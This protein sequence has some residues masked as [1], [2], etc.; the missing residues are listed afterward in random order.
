MYCGICP[1]ATDISPIH[2]RHSPVTCM[3]E[4][5]ISDMESFGHDHLEETMGY[6]HTVEGMSL[7]SHTTIFVL[8]Q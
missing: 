6:E 8:I 3:H 1:H 5:H 4:K 7:K 2:A